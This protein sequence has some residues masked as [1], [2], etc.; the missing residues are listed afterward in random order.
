MI[1]TQNK[2]YLFFSLVF[3]ST[4]FFYNCKSTKTESNTLIEEPAAELIEEESILPLENKKE[5][6][7]LF[8]GDIMAHSVNYRISDYSKIW[9]DV[10]YLIEPADLAFGNIEAPIDTTQETQNYPNFNMSLEYVP[11]AIDAG[12][13]VFSL[14]NNHTNDQNLNGIKETEKTVRLS[15]F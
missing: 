3:F 7:L 12:F 9:R 5:L 15:A 1:F 8:A 11:A 10:Q 4:L 13:D 6:T 2:K 14:C